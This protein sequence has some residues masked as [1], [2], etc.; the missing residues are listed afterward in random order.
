MSPSISKIAASKIIA[1]LILPQPREADHGHV[2][3]VDRHHQPLGVT[4]VEP[5]AGYRCKDL[6]PNRRTAHANNIAR[7][8]KQVGGKVTP[9]ES[10]FSQRGLDT[11]GIRGVHVD[12]D[13]EVMRGSDITM[14]ARRVAA[15][16]EGT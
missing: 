2:Q 11:L 13:A 10:G 4:L 6:E 3:S 15:D 16:Y 5:H 14:E 1:N 7:N 12:P 9:H 8:A